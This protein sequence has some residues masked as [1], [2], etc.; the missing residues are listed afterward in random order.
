[1]SEGE[2][3]TRRLAT[4]RIGIA[5]VILARSTPVFGWLRGAYASGWWGW[6]DGRWTTTF[7]PS[8]PPAATRGLVVVRILA[9]AALLV[10]ARA[11][12]A[13]VV[14]TAASLAVLSQD[15]FAATH[16][17][18]LLSVTAALVAID[19]GCT[20]AWLPDRPIAPHASVWLLRAFV[21]SIYAWS[22]I[23]KMNGDWIS[24]RTIAAFHHD[25]LVAEPGVSWLLA[26][27]RRC[28]VLS[29][30]VASF[31]TLLV[32]ALLHPRARTIAWLA[33][34]SFHVAL[35]V[36]VRPDVF[37]L[38]MIVLLL[39]FASSDPARADPRTR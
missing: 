17:L 18:R 37:G 16:T 31:E 20:R 25:G 38:A 14:L 24:G 8:I 13:G 29:V 4:I 32:P 28:A 1:M 23:A 12:W 39:S 36:F 2:P 11:R 30:S 3:T 26:T 27:P 9:A 10:G 21:V 15:A 33:A 22:A 19:G 34:I 7:G 6:P 35:E 5:A